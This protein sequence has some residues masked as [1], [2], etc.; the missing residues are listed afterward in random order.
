MRRSFL[1][2]LSAMVIGCS[3]SA[4]SEPESNLL[5]DQLNELRNEVVEF[6]LDGELYSFP[7]VTDFGDT[8]WIFDD[9]EYSV[10]YMG[11]VGYYTSS[12]T[13]DRLLHCI[14]TPDKVQLA[15]L[16]QVERKDPRDG[17]WVSHGP[18]WVLD[19]DGGTSRSTYKWDELDGW[20]RTWYADGQLR[21]EFFYIDG[22][23]EGQ[24][25]GF[26]PNG[27]KQ[28]EATYSANTEIA[29]KS[30]NE[31]GQESR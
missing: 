27:M 26:W 3:S 1:L 17:R 16:K 22:M 15:E 2:L 13:D 31:K 9:A 23:R 5:Q 30:W 14:Y 6:R 11:V 20:S 4:P 28:W 29:G 12:A 10:I 8:T 25:S 19:R 7:A 21:H 18:E 24:G